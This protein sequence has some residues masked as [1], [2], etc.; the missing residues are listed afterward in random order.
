MTQ[1]PQTRRKAHWVWALLAFLYL[2]FVACGLRDFDVSA[3]LSYNGDVLDAYAVHGRD[4][5]VNDLETRLYAPFGQATP[6]AGDYVPNL[7]FQPNANLTLLAYAATGDAITATNVYYLLTYVLAFALAYYVLGRLGLRN[8][9]RFCAATL[10]ALMPFHFQR[11]VNHLLESS[12]FLVPLLALILT[13]MWSA[14]PLLSTWQNDGWKTTFTDRRTLFALLVVVFL[15]SFHYYHQ[16]FFALLAGC[17]GLFAWTY[18]RSARHFWTAVAFAAV[19]VAVLVGKGMLQHALRD[20]VL[21]LSLTGASFAPYGE[22][23]HYPLKIIQVLLPVQDHRLA[24]FAHVRAVYDAAHDLVNENS[25][26]SLGLVGA[27]G[28]LVLLGAGLLSRGRRLSIVAKFGLLTVAIVLIAGMG[29][30]SSVVSTA[31]MEL[32]GPEFVLTQA[33]AWNRMIIFVG[34]FAYAASFLCLQWGVDRLQRRSLRGVS[35]RTLGWFVTLPVL[36]FAL[37]DQVPYKI[38]NDP[39]GVTAYRSDKA[40]FSRIESRLP[41]G[42]S[43]L[44]LPLVV[45]HVSG[46]L[47]GVYY[48]DAFRPYLASST[49]KFS[50]GADPDS[51]QTAWLKDTLARPPREMLL[52]ACRYGFA[53]ILLHRGMVADADALDQPF[54]ALLGRGDTTGD[55]SFHP[56]GAYCAANRIAPLDRPAAI[57]QAVKL[58]NEA[59]RTTEFGV[60]ALKRQTGDMET[61]AAGHACVASDAG[62][63][64]YLAYGPYVALTPG[65]YVARFHLSTVVPKGAVAANVDVATTQSDGAVLVLGSQV[66]RD[67]DGTGDVVVP[68]TVS[69]GQQHFE[70]RVEASGTGEVRFCGVRVQRFKP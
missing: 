32:F 50:F 66:V 18:R 51:V 10:Y 55:F 31:S 47:N 35:R 56:I 33:R 61:N 29:G 16:F 39:H 25:T 17:S 6:N 12:Y 19:A 60:D 21:D 48:T 7:L 63:R 9:Y 15:S 28:F 40:F 37:W 20:P 38:A 11:G 23:E 62:E 3:P 53:G 59:A 1:R 42:A 52:Q 58:A 30:F 70:F 27:A 43:I 46:A 57:A 4:N 13:W 36:A 54:V 5:A 67:A 49:L 14:R 45:N 68:F 41:H 65:E 24:P 22:A 34:F 26:T 8:P 69:E 44:Q 2:F 64:G